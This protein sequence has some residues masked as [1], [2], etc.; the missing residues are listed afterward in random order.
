MVIVLYLV[1]CIGV[2]VG[3]SYFFVVFVDDWFYVV[4]VVV[5]DFDVIFVEKVV[6]FVLFWEVFRNKFEKCFVDVSFDVFI[7]RRVV[8]DNIFLFVV[9]RL[10][11]LFVFVVG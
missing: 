3:I 5:V 6:V 7:E 2:I 4:Y 8:L 1:N 10:C 11:R 9:L